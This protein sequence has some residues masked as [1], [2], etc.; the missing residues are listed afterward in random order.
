MAC[1]YKGDFQVTSHLTG[2]F[3]YYIKERY[4]M[5]LSQPTYT[6]T[7]KPNNFFAE[8]P[9]FGYQHLKYPSTSFDSKKNAVGIA[10]E[11]ICKGRSHLIHQN[12]TLH[13]PFGI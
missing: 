7:K 10:K 2:A 5:N 11:F 9:E 8:F 6:R 4:K 3:L 12:Q 13:P 1:W